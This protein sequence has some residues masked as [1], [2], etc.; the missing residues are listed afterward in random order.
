MFCLVAVVVGLVRTLNID[1]KVL[2]L[3]LGELRELHVKVVEVETS[4]LKW[5]RRAE[6][7]GEKDL[8]IKLLG[9]EVDANLVLPRLSPERDLGEDLRNVKR[10][11]RERGRTWL[12]KELDMT[13]EGW[14]V[15]Q[16]RLTRRPSARRIMWR[17]LLSS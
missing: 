4:N 5:V 15:A 12:V 14:P 6:K 1:A 9:E 13:N 16:P 10:S 8:L 11:K 2:S 17:P 7:Q 3:I